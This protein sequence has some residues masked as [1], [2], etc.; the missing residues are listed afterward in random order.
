LPA[1]TIITAEYDPLRDE[2]EGYRAA[3]GAAGVDARVSRY[4][5]MMHGFNLQPGKFDDGRRA[6]D[7]AGDRL[8]QAFAF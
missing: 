5:G 4:D 8:R 2:G 1:A 3:L 7:E 6:L